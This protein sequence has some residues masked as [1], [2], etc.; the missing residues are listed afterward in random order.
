MSAKLTVILFIM[1]CFEIGGLLL[2]LPWHR[3]WQEN[4]FLYY[5]SDELNAPW[6][7]STVASGYFRGFVSGLGLVNIIIGVWEIVN[8]RASVRAFTA[9]PAAPVSDQ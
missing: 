9:G 8:F 7:A 6:I 4:S 5:V 3:S 2:V 1:I